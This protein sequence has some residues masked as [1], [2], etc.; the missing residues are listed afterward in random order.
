MNNQQK[1]RIQTA[2]DSDCVIALSYIDVGYVDEIAPDHEYPMCIIGKL[3]HDMGVSNESLAAHG[4]RGITSS[5]MA[6]IVRDLG[7][8]YGLNRDQLL[9]LQK[10]NDYG[11]G[12]LPHNIAKRRSRVS[13]TLG[14]F[15]IEEDDE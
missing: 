7:R 14:T 12:S 5:L 15:L 1:A 3:M 11:S 8:E 9:Q 4:S 6:P 13:L 2:I 10:A